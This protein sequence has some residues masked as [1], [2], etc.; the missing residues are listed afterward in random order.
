MC[1]APSANWNRTVSSAPMVAVANPRALSA[2]AISA[3]GFSCSSHANTSASLPSGPRWACSIA[4]SSSNL[5][6]TR[7]AFPLDGMIAVSNRSL[8]PHL[9][10]VKYS[11][12]VPPVS[13]SA[14][15][16]LALINAR[17]LS[18]RARRSSTEIGFTCPR[19]DVSARMAGGRSLAGWA[20]SASKVP[21]PSRDARVAPSRRRVPSTRP[22]A[23]AAP[24][25]RRLRRVGIV[26]P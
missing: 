13:I 26:G 9:I 23:A 5:G 1:A 17:A 2:C 11:I 16:L 4:R 7:N 15:I 6:V 12:L 8:T 14:S 10:P 24:A 22:A 18:S 19:I 20:S 25:P 3:Y 21:T